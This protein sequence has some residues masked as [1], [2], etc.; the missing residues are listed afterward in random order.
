MSLE[1]NVLKNGL[2]SYSYKFRWHGRTYRGHLGPLSLRQ[3]KFAEL[4]ARVLA[5]EGKHPPPKR[6]R[7]AAATAL[8]P[9]P[10]WNVFTPRFLAWYATDARPRSVQTYLRRLNLHILVY[11][12]DI[13]LSDT[14]AALFDEYRTIRRQEGASPNTVNGELDTMHHLLVKAAEWGVIAHGSRITI[15]HLKGEARPIRVLTLDEEARLLMAAT[16]HLRPLIRFALNTGLRRDE[17]L[18]LRWPD[19]NRQRR[20]VVVVAHRA[21]N[22]HRRTVPLNHTAMAA[23]DEAHTLHGRVFGYHSISAVFPKA[24]RKAG[25]RGVSPHV[26]RHSFA[27]RCVEAGIDVETLRKWLGHQSLAVTLRYFH[28]SKDHERAA[29]ERVGK[30]SH[31]R[32]SPLG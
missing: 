26:L 32:T 1:T 6:Q 5:A 14:S 15:R 29:I 4:Q 31:R 28:I 16:P 24:V 7:H 12:A 2:V 19:V 23:L 25:L 17:L 27:T 30:T 13:K 22:R 3:A 10:T 18:H 21:K 9:V 11:F 8:V 20:E